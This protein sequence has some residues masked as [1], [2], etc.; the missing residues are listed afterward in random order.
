M[1]VAEIIEMLRRRIAQLGQLRSSAVTLGDI[2]RVAAIDG[3][4][5]ETQL[6]LATLLAIDD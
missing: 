2:A 5:A 1:T 6:T 4:L 3:D